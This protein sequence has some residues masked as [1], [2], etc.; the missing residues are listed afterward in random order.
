MVNWPKGGCKDKTALYEK[1]HILCG[2][3]SI[4]EKFRSSVTK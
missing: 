1:N 4:P 2:K 3:Y